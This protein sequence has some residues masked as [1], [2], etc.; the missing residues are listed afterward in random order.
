MTRYFALHLSV[1]F[2]SESHCITQRLYGLFVIYFRPWLIQQELLTQLHYVNLK[3]CLQFNFGNLSTV[4][5]I[6]RNKLFL[7][8]AL[9]GREK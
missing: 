7:N 2:Q 6:F 5:C 8:L 4:I 9:F 3:I 1:P